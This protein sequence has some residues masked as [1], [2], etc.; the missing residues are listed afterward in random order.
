MIAKATAEFKIEIESFAKHYTK[1]DA[2]RDAW[3]FINEN[4]RD[5]KVHYSGTEQ[6]GEHTYTVSFVRFYA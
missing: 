1:H 5:S 2:R 6:T 3:A 4:V